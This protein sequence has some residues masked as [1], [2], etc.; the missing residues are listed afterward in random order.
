MS[1]LNVVTIKKG[2]L[3]ETK[4][5]NELKDIQEIVEGYIEVVML[6]DDMALICNED[7]KLT[8]KYQNFHLGNKIEGNNA[9]ML[10]VINGNALIVGSSVFEE[11]FLSLTDEQVKRIKAEM[12]DEEQRVFLIK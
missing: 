2:I 10:D 3:E 7:G 11:D 8:G 6:N 5:N 9:K 4:I 1:K 12:Y